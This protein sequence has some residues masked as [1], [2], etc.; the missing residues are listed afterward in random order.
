MK[1]LELIYNEILGAAVEEQRKALT[2]ASLAS[3]LGISLSTVHHALMPLQKMHAIQIGKRSFT[4]VDGKKILLYWASIR[5]IEKDILYQ[6]RAEGTVLDIEKR[7]PSGVL[8][9]TYSA[10]KFLFGNIPAE[11]SEVYVYAT[12]LEEM[13]RRFPPN[14][15]PPNLFVLRKDIETM[16]LANIF[17]DLWNL[18]TWYAK[19]FLKEVGEKL[20]AV[21]A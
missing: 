20:E 11:Y 6:T 14:N 17:V 8:F 9:G 18:G 13:K 16:T 19:E 7:M 5:N 3:A 1:K 12:E 10:Y 15:N 2:Q 21:L 4:V